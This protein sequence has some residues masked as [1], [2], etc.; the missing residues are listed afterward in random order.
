M[1]ALT[2]CMP[3]DKHERLKRLARER[4]T[5]VNGLIDEMATIILA[6]HDAEV[7]TPRNLIALAACGEG[8]TQEG[9]GLLRRAMGE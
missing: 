2:V 3:D 7:P 6:T 4:G 1:S 8:R 9:S 5:T